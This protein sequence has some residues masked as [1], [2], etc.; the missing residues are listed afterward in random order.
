MAHY[1]LYYIYDYI[2]IHCTFLNFTIKLY[3]YAELINLWIQKQ[4]LSVI[5][6]K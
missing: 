4:R 1:Y 5:I 2:I 3:T 6:K